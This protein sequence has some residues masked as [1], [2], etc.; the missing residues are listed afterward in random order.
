MQEHSN[1]P[2]FFDKSR[3]RG[4][5]LTALAVALAAL[6]LAATVLFVATIL[7]MPAAQ[8]KTLPSSVRAAPDLDGG[9]ALPA[10][11]KPLTPIARAELR[12]V[13]AKKRAHHRSQAQ[14]G[15]QHPRR[16][17]YGRPR[18]PRREYRPRTHHRSRP[19]RF[20]R[21]LRAAKPGIA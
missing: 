19:R 21:Q 8:F 4:R 11:H 14:I 9:N 15:R 20:L 18:H 2:V 16:A 5:A 13:I 3:K 1:E 7:V 12:Y 10:N 17:K 6:S